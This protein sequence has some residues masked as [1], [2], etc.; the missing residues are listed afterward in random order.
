MLLR[1]WTWNTWRYRPLGPLPSHFFV[2]IKFCE[3]TNKSSQLCFH[4]I[5]VKGSW[6]LFNPLKT[7]FC[8]WIRKTRLNIMKSKSLTLTTLRLL[9]PSLN[10]WPK[11]TFPFFCTYDLMVVKDLVGGA[12]WQDHITLFLFKR[13]DNFGLIELTG[14]GFVD[15]TK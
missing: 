2:F 15:V 5:N 12:W 14:K 4:Y 13:K 1:W 10:V 7:I 3:A 9:S 11:R 6:C 8:A